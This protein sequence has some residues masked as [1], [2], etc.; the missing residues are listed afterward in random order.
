MSA[1]LL[2]GVFRPRSDSVLLADTLGLLASPELRVLDVC[3]GSG[4][5]AIAAARAGARTTAVD[6][7]WRAVQTTRIN[8]ALNGVKVDARRADLFEAVD[9]EKF[10]IIASNPPYLPG[11]RPAGQA[12]GAARA[13]EG[14]DRGRE[15]IDRLIDEA[16]RYLRPGGRLLITHSS[17]CGFEATQSRMEDVGMEA[18]LICAERGPLGPLM[19]SRAAALEAAGVLAPGVRE[20]DIGI[21]L[22]T[23]RGYRSAVKGN[24]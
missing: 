22:G 2:P 24:K 17:I 9:G 21:L 3:T 1:L 16:P 4:V 11:T 15:V 7:S 8:A 19:A 12:K 14:G 5:V 20:E 13:W 23:L 6:V 18:S 10:D